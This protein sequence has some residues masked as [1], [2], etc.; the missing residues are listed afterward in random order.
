MNK[1]PYDF[2]AARRMDHFRMKLQSEGFPGAILDRRVIRI[3]RDRDRPESLRKACQF[4]AVRIPDLK[5]RRQ[6]H[7]Q[8]AGLVLYGEVALAVFALLARLYFPAEVMREN[9]KPVTNSQDWNVQ[10]EDILV[11]M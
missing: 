1:I 7:E 6:R 11:R 10:F 3:L 9:L 2:R 8:G 4:I 5:L